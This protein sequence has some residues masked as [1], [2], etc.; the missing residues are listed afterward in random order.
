MMKSWWGRWR[1]R[2]RPLDKF[3]PDRQTHRQTDRQS[4]SLG[5][6]TEPKNQNQIQKN[7]I[8]LLLIKN[9]TSHGFINFIIGWGI[10]SSSKPRLNSFIISCLLIFSRICQF[11]HYYESLRLCYCL[12]VVIYC[13]LCIWLVRPTRLSIWIGVNLI[14]YLISTSLLWKTRTA[15]LIPSKWIH[16]SLPLTYFWH[17]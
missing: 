8:L 12:P 7:K 9:V 13:N 1:W 11:I 4:D 17:F 10:L 5:S 3:V 15:Y 16:N 2:L 14:R 6:L